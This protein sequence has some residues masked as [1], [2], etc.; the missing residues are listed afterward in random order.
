V[1]LHAGVGIS[2]G[3]M[4]VGNIGSNRR[5]DYTVIGDTV[6]L[7]S[8]I[9]G[10]NKTYGTEILATEETVRG[11]SRDYIV[12]QLDRV[13]VKGKNEPV[14]LYE[15]ISF[16]QHAAPEV[17]DKLDR[18]ARALARYEARDF[19]GAYIQFGDI[20]ALNPS[21][22]P[23]HVFWERSKYFMENPPGADWGGVWVMQTK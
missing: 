3:D 2:T 15:V 8:R 11:L 5:F 16:R 6:N 12:R 9:E 4:I 7:G 20:L 10:L 17:M 14:R 23:S 18:F 21:D 1:T 19:H 22:A 13:A